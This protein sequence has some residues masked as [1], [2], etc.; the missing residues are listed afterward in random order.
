MFHQESHGGRRARAHP[1]AVRGLERRAAARGV[2]RR[3]RRALRGRRDPS[4][5][6]NTEHR[7]GGVRVAAIR[8]DARGLPATTRSPR[9]QPSGR[10]SWRW[11]S[12]AA[13]NATAGFWHRG[14]FPQAGLV[15]TS[16]P[17]LGPQSWALVAGLASPE[18]S[19]IESV[20][21]EVVSPVGSIGGRLNERYMPGGAVWPA[22]SHPWVWA[23]ARAG[24]AS[25]AWS[26]FGRLSLHTTATAHPTLWLGGVGRRPTPEG[27]RESTD[28]STCQPSVPTV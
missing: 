24:N 20:V 18:Q 28:R 4:G 5:R 25:E 17:T 10:P 7:D 23:L 19:R 22:I 26:E 27:P 11:T 12:Q 14:W 8:P 9:R 2:P 15:G 3:P 6:V 16:K 13:R 21:T 1:S